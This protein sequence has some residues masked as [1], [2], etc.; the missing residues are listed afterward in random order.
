MKTKVPVLRKGEFPH[1]KGVVQVIDDEAIQSVL[2]QEIPP[3]GL[4]FDFDH[5]SDL[6]NDERT[7]LSKTGIMLP[8]DASGWIHSFTAGDDGNTVYAEVDWTEAGEKAVRGGAYK[9]TSPVF[10]RTA[11]EYLGGNRVRPRRISKV[12]LTNEPNMKTIGAILANRDALANGGAEAENVPGPVYETAISVGAHGASHEEKERMDEKLT[13]ALGLEKDATVDAAVAAIETLKTAKTDGETA[14]AEAESK[15]TEAETKSAELANRVAAMET[16][17]KQ[18]RDEK[19]KAEQDALVSAELAKYPS[20]PNREAAEAM[21]RADMNAGKAFLE[22]MKD[23]LSKPAA[24]AGKGANPE[25]TIKNREESKPE[26]HGVD[27]IA[28]ALAAKN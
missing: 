25:E 23:T 5:Y 27:R 12:A 1:S 9:Y 18:L 6:T 16:E 17:L 21:L 11:C 15:A 7:A 14:K 4:L 28:A 22:S 3:E 2:A 19:A 13:A 26:L 20:L 24:N 10:P 8:S